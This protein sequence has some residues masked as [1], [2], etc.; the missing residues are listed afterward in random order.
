MT[1]IVARGRVGVNEGFT[2]THNVP[3][4]GDIDADN[5]G[6][7]T[8]SPQFIVDLSAIAG[9]RLGYQAS[10]MAGYKIHRITVGIRPVD[11]AAD[12]DVQTAFAG[13]IYMYP[14]TDHCKTA[15]QLARR[16]EKADEENQIDEDSLFLSNAVD[17]SGFRYGWSNVNA[18]GVEHITANGIAGMSGYWYLSDIFDAYDN[19]TEPKQD[20]ALFGGRAPENMGL[21]WVCSWSTGMDLSSLSGCQDYQVATNLTVLPLLQ[22]RVNYSSGDEAGGIDDDYTV[23]VSIEFTPEFGGVF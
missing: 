8:P 22:G 18:G 12:N 3:S 1:R 7:M 6:V 20:N 16:V 10:M 5:D 9:S 19:M 23:E 13:D 17:Y 15:L 11:D 14:L 21:P 2:W 4:D